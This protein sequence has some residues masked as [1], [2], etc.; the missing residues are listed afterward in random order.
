MEHKISTKPLIVAVE[1]FTKVN[2]TYHTLSK[3]MLKVK[4]GNYC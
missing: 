4:F 3:L 1:V 2:K